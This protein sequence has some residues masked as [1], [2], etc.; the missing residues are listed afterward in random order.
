[1]K[2]RV[3]IACDEPNYR[4]SIAGLLAGRDDL[5]VVGAGPEGEVG[6][7]AL[8]KVEPDVLVL[9]VPPS[10]DAAAHTELYKGAV[11]E[12]TGV[13]AFCTVA[14]QEAGYRNAGV[15]AIIHS[16]DPPQALQEAI[17][18]ASP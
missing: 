15:E 13:V 1:M 3:H 16:S 4:S 10:E 5:E 9:A 6:I 8:K 17:Y 14:S 11:S 7:A 2:I 18:S 12:T